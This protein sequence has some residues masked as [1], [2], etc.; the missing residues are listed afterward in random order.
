MPVDPKRVQAVF[1]T[2]VERE[3]P[4]HRATVLDRECAT[5]PEL[6]QRVEALLRPTTV[7]TASSTGLS[8]DPANLSGVTLASGNDGGAATESS[9]DFTI[10]HH[11][12]ARVEPAAN[13]GAAVD[14][15]SP[16]P[17]TEG[18]GTR[19]GPYKLLQ[20]I[21]EGGMGVVY[22]AEQEEPVRRRVALKIIKPGMDTRAGHRPV[23]GRAPGPGADG[24]PEH[25]P[26]PRRRHHRHRPP[27]LRHGAGPRR[28]DHRVLRRG[29]AHPASGWSCSSR[30]ARRSSTPTR[31]GSST[32]TSSR[33]TCW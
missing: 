30:S 7:P 9:I 18:P 27:L 3:D 11:F 26:G 21:G 16:R 5:D 12:K 10:N 14:H 32:A 4:V 28:P 1:L 19:I 15:P 6:R 31:R 33:R 25:R 17:I 2:A 20:Q 29:P 24:P 13:G 8:P 22:M 23:R